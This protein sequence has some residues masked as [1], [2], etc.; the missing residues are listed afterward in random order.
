MNK[1]QT[2]EDVASQR[3]QMIT[4]LLEDG[5]DHAQVVEL[6][7]KICETHNLSYRSISRYHKAYLEKGFSGLKPNRGYKRN[8]SK[9]PDNFPEVVEQA[10]ILRRECPTRSVTDIIRILEFEEFIPK[11]SIKRST[12]QRHL[13]ASGFGAKQLKMYQK[14]GLASRRYAKTHRMQLLQGDIKYGPY[15]P[16]GKD[17]AMKQV[18]LSAFIDDATRFIV[19]AKFYDNQQTEIIE[20]S[21]REAIMAYGKPDKIFVDNGKQYRSDW[22]KKACNRLDIR[23]SFSRPYHPEGKGKIEFFNRRIDSFLAEVAL[24]KPKSLHALNE[25]LKLWIDEY[26]H[27]NPHSG[28]DGLSPSAVF[29]SDKRKLKFA[30][31][32][33]LREAFLHTVTR[34]VDKTGCVSFD[35][36]KYD[37]GMKLIGRKVEVYY[38]HTWKDEIEIHHP[39]VEPYKAKVMVIGENC[40]YIKELPEHMSTITP[41][42]SRLLKGLNRHNITHK[43]KGETAISFKHMGG[44]SHV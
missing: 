42:E 31:S 2:I 36:N 33:E 18:Y 4:P 28:L 6:K 39:D 9:L 22:L 16:I 38:D 14:T 26:Y 17:G 5:L 20:D 37:V 44:G 34:Q 41:E 11:D 21:L 25:A 43:T 29:A 40:G 19:A 27:K 8:D 1:T 13:Q 7:K 24:N 32:D 30:P 35:G 3:L 15:L 23:L 12:L 10:I